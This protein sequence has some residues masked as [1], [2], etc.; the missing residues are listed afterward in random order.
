MQGNFKQMLEKR[1]QRRSRQEESEVTNQMTTHK[2]YRCFFFQTQQSASNL[3]RISLSEP[4][5]ALRLAG[6]S[7][8]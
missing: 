3:Y 1:G 6:N 8:R 7:K 4:F 2:P 5:L